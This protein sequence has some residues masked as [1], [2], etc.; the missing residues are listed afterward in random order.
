MCF[1]PTAKR[2][3]FSEYPK[4]FQWLL[5]KAKKQNLWVN[6]SDLENVFFLTE[7]SHVLQDT[8]TLSAS[9]KIAKLMKYLLFKA[10]L[11]KYIFIYYLKLRCD[12]FSKIKGEGRG[13]TPS[14]PPLGALLTLYRTFL[15]QRKRNGEFHSKE[16]V[17]MFRLHNSLTLV[18]FLRACLQRLSLLSCV[19]NSFETTF[20]IS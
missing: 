5:G 6:V 16:R 3:K 14:V 4:A 20:Q 7:K 11:K 18:I 1:D 10:T 2:Q 12:N 9:E 19:W 17:T 15:D 13:R 8:I